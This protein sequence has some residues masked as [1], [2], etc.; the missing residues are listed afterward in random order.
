MSKP[1]AAAAL[2]ALP[3]MHLLLADERGQALVAEYGR[4]QVSAALRTVLADARRQI[5]NGSAHPNSAKSLLSRAESRLRQDFAPTLQPVI[6]ATGVILHTNLGRAPLSQAAREAMAAVA[7]GYSSLEYE[8]Q[9]GRRG[10]RYTHAAGALRALT[11]AEDALVVNNNASALVLLLS[12]L[13]RG[14]EVVISRGQLVEIGGGFRIPAIMAES[15]AILRE[16]GSTNRTRLSDYAAA[17]GANT[18]LL[19]RVHPSNFRQSGFVEA[20]ALAE[21]VALGR[22]QGLPVADDVGS[23]ALL[24]T[25]DYGLPAEPMAQESVAAG[26]DVVLFSG[27]K[28]LGGPQAGILV[29]KGQLIERLRRHPLAR[30]LRTDKLTLAALSATLSSYLRGR[31]TEEIPI[32]RMIAQTPAAVKQ[33]A[34]RWQAVIGGRVVATESTVGGGSLPGGALPSYALALPTTKADRL[35][36]ALR[37]GQPPVIGRIA[38]DDMLLDPRT[39]LPEQEEMLLKNVQ[40]ALTQ[41]AD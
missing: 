29:G 9:S 26:A 27:D 4:G 38:G 34:E 15:G 13:A 41:A 25:Q 24:N 17:I 18:G 19:L 16:V 14:R 39:V 32:W 22:E 1:A 21:L 28:L 5:L 33:R 37:M 2:R 30:A 7:G 40:R 35:L 11:G 8:L 3:A 20:T 10:S 12:A 23:G 31:A 36:A 6:N